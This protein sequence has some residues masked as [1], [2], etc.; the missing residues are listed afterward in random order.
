M[1]FDYIINPNNRIYNINTS[2]IV[3]THKSDIMKS[4]I[5]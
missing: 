3:S 1:G 5:G 4:K 2:K